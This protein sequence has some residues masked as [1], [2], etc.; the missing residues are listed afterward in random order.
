MLDRESL[1]IAFMLGLEDVAR[2]LRHSHPD[3]FAKVDA[4]LADPKHTPSWD[5]RVQA[6]FNFD[7]LRWHQCCECG[8]R[9][10]QERRSRGWRPLTCGQP[11]CVN[12]SRKTG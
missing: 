4:V 11:A 7:R 2:A 9:V 6:R 8:A 5:A 3:V 12:G 10:L 1:G